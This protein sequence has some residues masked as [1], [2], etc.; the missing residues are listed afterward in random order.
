MDEQLP[1][2]SNREDDDE[3]LV[4]PRFKYERIL[5]DV[6]KTLERDSASCIAVHDKFL[7]IGFSSGRV[8]FFDHLGHGHFEC[9]E[10]THRCSVSH[11]AVDGPG[12]YVISCANDNQVCIQG[13]GHTEL[14]QVSFI[15]FLDSLLFFRLLNF[16]QQLNVS[17]WLKIS[18]NQHQDNVLLQVHNA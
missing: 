8:C 9:N 10:K 12:N 13:F 5:D 6:A 15:H 16:D 3:L 4:E 7:A 18:R 11:I 14:N 2:V 17:L 1:D